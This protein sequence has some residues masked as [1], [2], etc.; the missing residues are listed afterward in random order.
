MNQLGQNLSFETAVKLMNED[1]DNRVATK[2]GWHHPKQAIGIHE[3]RLCLF[4]LPHTIESAPDEINVTGDY[5]PLEGDV[6]SLWD[7]WRK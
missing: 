4:E 5:C 1:Q 3:G 7:V 6:S 2:H